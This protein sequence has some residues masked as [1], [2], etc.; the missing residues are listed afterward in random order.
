[1]PTLDNALALVV[2]IAA[3][4]HLRPLPATVLNDA[5]AVAGALT[6]PAVGAYDPA[7]VRI[8]LDEAATGPGLRAALSDLATAASERSTVLVYFSGHGG[9]LA[10]G[11]SPGDYLLPID[12]VYPDEAAL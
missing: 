1:M 7:N 4:R 9:R 5:A 3:Y 2:G 8:L 12:A 6:D 10:S 11:V